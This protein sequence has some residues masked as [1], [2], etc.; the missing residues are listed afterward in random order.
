MAE[1][2]SAA[3][4]KMFAIA[5]DGGGARIGQDLL[6][7]RLAVDQGRIDQIVAVEM[8][9]VE[10][11]VDETIA[12]SF[13]EVVLQGG[14]VRRPIVAFDHD[15]A[16]GHGR[17]HGQRR[18][19]LADLGPEPLRPVEA[20]A[21][22]QGHFA[23]GDMGLKTI[24]V[25]LDF[26]DPVVACRRFGLQ[27]RQRRLDERRLFGLPGTGRPGDPIGERRGAGALSRPGLFPIR[28]AVGLPDCCRVFRYCFDCST[29]LG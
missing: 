21:G 23:S 20:A 29:R 5:Q 4:A 10:G 9:K 2:Q 12:A 17:R 19:C 7:N 13:A 25:K 1:N 11:I 28:L 18:E 26:M 22:Q 24:A 15:L 6:Q 16:I 3:F 27:L 8:Q 14:K